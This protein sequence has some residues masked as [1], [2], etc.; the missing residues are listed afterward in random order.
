MY[1]YKA[2]KLIV[3]DIIKIWWLNNQITEIPIYIYIYIDKRFN[4][5]AINCLSYSTYANN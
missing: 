4:A 1:A 5:Q 3:Y 2:I